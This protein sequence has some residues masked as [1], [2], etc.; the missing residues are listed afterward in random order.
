MSERLERSMKEIFALQD[1]L[2]K[3]IIA[4]LQAKLTEGNTARLLAMGTPNIEAY[5]KYLEDILP[6]RR[7]YE[8]YGL[9]GVVDKKLLTRSVFLAERH[10]EFASPLVIAM[11]ELAVLIAFGVGLFVLIP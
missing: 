5:L 4:A 6:G 7:V 2:T 10:I 1:D 11:A 9:A 8:G 3:S